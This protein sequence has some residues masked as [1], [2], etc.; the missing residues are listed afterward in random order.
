MLR[1]PPLPASW[2]ILLEVFRPAFRRSSTFAVFALL[3]A[4]LVAQAMRRTVVG[5]LTATGMTAIVSYHTCCRFFSH[6]AWDADPL[7][8]ALARLVVCRLLPDGAPI[9]AVV[10]DTL[11]RR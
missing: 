10:D 1:G 7:G 4:I 2:R 3:A 8:L 5:M 9:E 6:H 11:F